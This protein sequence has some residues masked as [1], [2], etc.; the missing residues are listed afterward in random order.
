MRAIYTAGI[1]NHLLFS[2]PWLGSV[3]DSLRPCDFA[4]L[5]VWGITGPEKSFPVHCEEMR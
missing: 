1:L 4:G 2:F 3:R 5:P